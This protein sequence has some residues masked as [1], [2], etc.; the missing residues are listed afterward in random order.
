MIGD[1]NKTTISFN[2][3]PQLNTIH[4]FFEDEELRSEKFDEMNPPM[5]DRVQTRIMAIHQKLI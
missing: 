5:T 3:V 1:N 2:S 4:R